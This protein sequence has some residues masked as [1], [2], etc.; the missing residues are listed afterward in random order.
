MLRRLKWILFGSIVLAIV[1]IAMQNLDPVNVHVL[2]YHF[3]AKLAT[4]LMCAMAIG[5][6]LGISFRT[7]WRVTTWTRAKTMKTSASIDRSD[8]A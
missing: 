3:S 5:F 2:V 1:I 7:M 8:D 6:V 4:L